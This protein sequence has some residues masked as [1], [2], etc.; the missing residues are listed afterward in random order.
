MKYLFLILGTL[1]GL[2]IGITIQP[3]IEKTID[4]NPIVL[5]PK[6]NEYE[7]GLNITTEVE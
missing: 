1:I 2:S 5:I 7:G 4:E 3:K 6:E